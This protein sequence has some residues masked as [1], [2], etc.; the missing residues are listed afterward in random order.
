MKPVSRLKFIPKTNFQL[1]GLVSS[2]PILRLS[3]V[4]NQLL[5]I[6]L[7]TTRPL[8]I[9]HENFGV[10]QEY[11]VYQYCR[12]V[13]SV[14]YRLVENKSENGNLSTKFSG[15]D[16]FLQCFIQN[17]TNLKKIKSALKSC[18]EINFHSILNDDD[19]QQK[20]MI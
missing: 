6:K 18:D 4:L 7:S 8:A 1:I 17:E 15:F 13:D 11:H 16:Y 14:L 5:R 12:D 19:L 10:F 2:E 20:L 9:Y 3:W